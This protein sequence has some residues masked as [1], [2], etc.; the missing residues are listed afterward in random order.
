MWAAKARCPWACG[1]E[2]PRMPASERRFVTT[3]THRKT[4]VCA[5]RACVSLSSR[6]APHSRQPPCGALVTSE[7]PSSLES[8]SHRQAGNPRGRRERSLL[9]CV[10]PP[11]HGDKEEAQPA[12]G[13]ER[14]REAGTSWLQ[15]RARGCLRRWLP[16]PWGHW[17]AGRPPIG[18][19][20]PN[21]TEGL[22]GQRGSSPSLSLGEQGF[23]DTGPPGRFCRKQRNEGWQH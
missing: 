18:V 17:L 14:V 22:W 15:T 1:Q 23:R 21:A 2:R 16:D 11:G 20:W 12:A 19:P 7:R 10:S 6:H 9:A 8:A 3:A 5:F 4:A 13:P